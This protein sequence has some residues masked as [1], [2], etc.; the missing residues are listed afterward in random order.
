ME[1]ELALEIKGDVTNIFKGLYSLYE[2]GYG[3]ETVI[4]S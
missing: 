3:H 2:D 4:I 1:W